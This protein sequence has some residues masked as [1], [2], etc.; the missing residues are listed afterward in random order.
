MDASS[1]HLLLT[2]SHRLIFTSAWITAPSIH[3]SLSCCQFFKV[4]SDESRI[5]DGSIQK[6][7][8]KTNSSILFDYYNSW[9]WKWTSRWRSTPSIIKNWKTYISGPSNGNASRGCKSFHA[10]DPSW[11]LDRRLTPPRSLS[12]ENL[13]A[14]SAQSRLRR[15]RR[16]V[17]TPRLVYI[18]TNDS[19]D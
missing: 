16:W 2:G 9:A 5:C 6:N 18:W 17:L 12:G 7:K 10:E 14:T 1:F 3:A 8:I 11:R 19:F 13:T 4:K 15:T